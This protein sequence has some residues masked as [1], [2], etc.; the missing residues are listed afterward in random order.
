MASSNSSEL[1]KIKQKILINLE[2]IKI[3]IATFFD[4]FSKKKIENAK[5]TKKIQIYVEQIEGSVLAKYI[6][7]ENC[8]LS[9]RLRDKKW[10]DRNLRI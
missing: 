3:F 5:N 6:V 1:V 2:P 7:F 10:K 9:I 4:A 8:P